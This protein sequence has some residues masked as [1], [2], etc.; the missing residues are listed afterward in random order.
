MI[1]QCLVQGGVAMNEMKK[2]LIAPCGMNCRLCIGYQREKNKCA[3]C[4]NEIDIRYITKGCVSCIIKNCH[5]IKENKSGFCFECDKMPCRRLK[6]LDKRYKTKY[7]MSMLEN[8][9]YIKENG[10]EKFID[11]E[12][13]RW[14]CPKCGN[15]VSV[16]R[17][18]C[19]KCGEKIFD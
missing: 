5:V 7:H 10:I 19:Q 14:A 1:R 4:R 12:E 17:T 11:N 2:E 15:I 3:G 16:H 13:S 6:Q 8:L 9:N 18:E